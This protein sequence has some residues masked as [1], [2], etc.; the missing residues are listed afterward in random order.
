M[1]QNP[2][3]TGG[4]YT[5]LKRADRLRTFIRNALMSTEPHRSIHRLKCRLASRQTS[6]LRISMSLPALAVEHTDRGG[7]LMTSRKPDQ[8]VARDHQR[9]RIIQQAIL[10]VI[11]QPQ[12]SRR[13]K[14]N[15]SILFR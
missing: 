11:L 9:T 2:Y 13:I 7:V 8:A 1:L 12:L 14:L 15:D 6:K 3:V 4:R 5:E 10:S